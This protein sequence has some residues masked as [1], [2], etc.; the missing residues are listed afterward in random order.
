MDWSSVEHIVAELCDILQSEFVYLQEP[1]EM[2]ETIENA[3]T[4]LIKKGL[5]LARTGTNLPNIRCDP[6]SIK[7]LAV[8]RSATAH[9]IE[10]SYYSWLHGS[11][12]ECTSKI[13]IQNLIHNSV[14]QDTTL[15][16]FY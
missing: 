16:R 6:Q 8:L 15:W 11:S 7:R 5:L 3:K 9:L 14:L 2:L 1:R 13:P 12:A 10:G 4:V